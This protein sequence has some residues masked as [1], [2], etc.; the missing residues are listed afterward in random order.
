MRALMFDGELRLAEVDEP[1][2]DDGEALV[3]VVKAGICGTDLELVRGYAS[4][5]GVPGHEMVGVVEDCE[6]APQWLGRRVV[7]EINLSCGRCRMCRANLPTHCERRRVLGIRDKQGAF[8]EL[9]TLPVANLHE[10]PPS[11]P[12]DAAVF[13]EPIAAAYRIL[14]QVEID[15]RDDVAVFGDGRLGLLVAMVLAPTGCRLTVVGRH[16]H[17]LAIAERIGAD[18]REPDDVQA[19]R[20]DVVIEATGNPHGVAAALAAV[21]PQ[22]VLVLKST[23]AAGTHLDTNR[24]VVDE[25][26][27][28]G[29]RCGAFE[30][31]L[32]ALAD[33]MLDPTVLVEDTYTLDDAVAAFAHAQRRGALKILVEP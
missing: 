29:S 17:K 26:E 13:T 8:A 7:G 10:V 6:T 24:I 20:F 28:L 14:Q 30:P 23:V 22:G 15:G 1:E 19:A 3:R 5:R 12:D 18:A 31:A 11:V 4:F 16:P 25:I 9:V 2:P 32:E 27:V 21:R 33:G